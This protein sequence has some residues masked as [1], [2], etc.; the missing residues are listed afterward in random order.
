MKVI[1]INGSPRAE[2]N[3]SLALREMARELATHGIETEILHIGAR[4]IRGCQA[5]GTCGRNKNG[6]C[7]ISGDGV[8]EAIARMREAD[9]I[10]LGS[11]V[12]F[13]GIGGTMK[14]FCDR[15][16][17]VAGANGG[18]FAG[19]VGASVVAVRRTGGSAAWQGLNFYITI[20]N[21]SLAGSSYWS[22]VHG[23]LP[24]EAADDA[25]GLQTVRNAARNMAW[26]LHL[27][28]TAE[29]GAAGASEGDVALPEPDR[30]A[31]TNFIR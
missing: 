11:P 9:G 16:F 12:H 25:E 23:A 17:Y 10:I 22:I 15:A 6:R 14:S 2:G 24:G 13:A 5:C 18:L 20:A 19:K 31:R 30:G 21:M 8:N 1:A 27:R 3:T 4:N 26:L 29:A 28:K 7:I